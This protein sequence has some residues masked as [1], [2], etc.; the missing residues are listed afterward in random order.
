MSHQD[1]REPLPKW[2]QFGDCRPVVTAHQHSFNEVSGYCACGLQYLPHFRNVF[3]NGGW[4]GDRR[5]NRYF[6]TTLEPEGIAAQL[7]R[8]TTMEDERE[9]ELMEANG[10]TRE[11]QE[12]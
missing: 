3:P 9:R 11:G 1:R 4:S 12:L 10:I 6:V 8:W 2:Y 7:A 5:E